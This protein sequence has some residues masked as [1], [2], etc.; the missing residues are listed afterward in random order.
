MGRDRDTLWI[1]P[2]SH[3]AS[4]KFLGCPGVVS[5]A[6]HSESNG[7]SPNNFYIGCFSSADSSVTAI[8]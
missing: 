3:S 4:F 8:S 7:I 5:A 1:D 6:R 2:V